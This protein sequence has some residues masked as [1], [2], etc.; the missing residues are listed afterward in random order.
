MRHAPRLLAAIA[1]LASAACVNDAARP[2]LPPD[3][4]NPRTP[5]TPVGVYQIHVTGIASEQITSTVRPVIAP[6]G[7]RG[8]LTQ[9]SNTG[10]VI[11][12]ISGSVVSDGPRGSD[13]QRYFT[14]TYRVRNATGGTRNNLTMLLTSTTATIPGTAFSSIT[15]PD[16]T[17]ADTALAK[18]IVPTGAV[19]MGRD[20]VTLLSPYPD[21]LQ[22]YSSGEI[23]GITPPSGVTNVFPVGFVVRSHGNSS[24]Q[25]VDATS[26]PNQF[27][28]ELT[29]AFRVPRQASAAN[30]VNGFFVQVIFVEDSDTRMTESIEESQDTGAVRRLRERAS[31][32]GATVVTVLAG[33]PAED[34][35]VTDYPGQRQICSVVTAG[36][37]ASPITYI[38]APAA[39]T[40][41]ALYLSGESVNSCGAYFRVNTPNNPSVGTPYPVT[42]K[43]MDR[44]GNVKAAAVDTVAVSRVSG[45]SATIGSPAA[46]VSGS[47][48]INV[49]YSSGSGV[50]TLEGVGRRLRSPTRSIYVP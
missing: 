14:V 13:G 26:S 10:L 23:S 37:E 21:V 39:Y 9:Y 42:L 11:E 30:D 12:Q 28:G 46:L 48:S 33:S 35:N 4:G 1:L 29:L 40:R 34:P 41:L 2:T 18:L 24:R 44:Y 19:T 8:T 5:I 25:L 49:T 32:L 27:D 15:R 7:M 45:P 16:G 3:A 50:S 31:S 20:G 6:S 36:T 43:A 47:A 22:V 38:T 17:S